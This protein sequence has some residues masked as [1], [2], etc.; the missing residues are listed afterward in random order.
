MK[1]PTHSA[2]ILA[3]SI[4]AL[5]TISSAARAA[6]VTST[7]TDPANG[8]WNVDANWMNAPA[9]GG[10][11]NNSNGGV[12]TYAAVIA[13]VGATYTVTLSTNVTVE[14]LVISSAN[15]ML[16]HTAG[17]FTATGAIALSAGTYQLNG[18][19]ISHTAVNVSGTGSLVFAASSTNL[20]GRGDGERGFDAERQQRAH[21]AG[22]GHDFHN[23]ASHGDQHGAGL[24][25]GLDAQRH[26]PF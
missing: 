21:A 22:R 11:P 10:F 19:T 20:L 6:T 23:R 25:A 13:A 5:L 18:G 1:T 17:M 16:N 8:T 7:W 9:L 14:D 3:A 15:A 24:C 2:R 4:A 26:D 12:P